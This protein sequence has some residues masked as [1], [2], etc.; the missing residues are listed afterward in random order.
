MTEECHFIWLNADSGPQEINEDMI[1]S[2]A[3]NVSG[4]V[5]KVVR[6]GN[7]KVTIHNAVDNTKILEI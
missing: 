5:I 3:E 4:P 2:A 6:H 7:G 1:Y